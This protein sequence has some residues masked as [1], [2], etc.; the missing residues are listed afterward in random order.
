[1]RDIVNALFLSAALL[2]GLAACAS[3]PKFDTSGVDKSLIPTAVAADIDAARG[4][5]AMWGG[6]VINSRNQERISEL[7][8]LAY[9]LSD[10]GRPQ[11]D[12]S[13]LGRFLV[14]RA[15]YLETV[16]YAPGR[17]ITAIG[18]V[19]GV[20]SGTVGAARYDYPVIEAR[21]L[22]LWPRSETAGGVSNPQFHFGIGI[23]VIR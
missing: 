4:R 21:E 6:T 17:L 12:Q 19:A 1:M 16:D 3:G 13:P 2:L 5:T 20:R 10:S 23:G 14:Q 18:P 15:G 7:E 11:L 8:V 22:H 9:P